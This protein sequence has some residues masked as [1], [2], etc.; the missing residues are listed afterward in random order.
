MDLKHNDCLHFCN[1]DAA[2]GICRVTKQL[3][4]IDS[5]VCDRLVLAPKCKNCEQFHDADENNLGIC[6][7]LAKDDWVYGSLSAVT[8]KAYT[9]RS[10]G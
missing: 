1:I 8:C 2:K 5:D 6:K 9:L 3:I 4:N 10:K 7:G